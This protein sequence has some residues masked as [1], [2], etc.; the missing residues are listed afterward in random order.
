MKKTSGDNGDCIGDSV[1][2][3]LTDEL[4]L[5]DSKREEHIGCFL[6]SAAILV[7]QTV[8]YWGIQRYTRRSIE[9]RRH[10]MAY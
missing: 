2:V 7:Y 4:R 8:T 5:A 1:V 6:L 9:E 3:M 10:A